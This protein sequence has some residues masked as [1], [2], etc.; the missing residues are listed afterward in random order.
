M[1][2][3][4]KM[5]DERKLGYAEGHEEGKRNCCQSCGDGS[6]GRTNRSRRKNQ[7]PVSSKVAGWKCGRDISKAAIDSAKVRPWVYDK[8][9][10]VQAR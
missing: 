7:H 6:S 4:Q 10:T 2:F 5:L 9:T 1:T 8:N 3:A